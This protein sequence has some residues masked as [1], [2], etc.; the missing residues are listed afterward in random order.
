MSEPQVPSWVESDGVEVWLVAGSGRGLIGNLDAAEELA[1]SSAGVGA[2]LAANADA[3]DQ[4][5]IRQLVESGYRR[6]FSMVELERDTA[7]VPAPATRGSIVTVTPPDAD[8]MHHLT[9][10]VWAGRRYFTMP[11]LESYRSWVKSADPQLML[12]CW[13]DATLIGYVAAHQDPT[14]IEIGDVQVHPHH[15]RSGVATALLA[16]VVAEANA[17]GQPRV[18]LQTEGDDPVGARRF[19]E[20]IGFHLR[21]EHLRFRKPARMT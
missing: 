16:R 11:T 9:T 5:R 20:H 3:D 13:N 2:A 18:W 21:V 4:Q 15:Q 10:L 14:G 8:A 6:V 12:L 7:P 17:R 1:R 19:Y